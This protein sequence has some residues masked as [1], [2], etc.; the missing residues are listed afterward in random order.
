MKLIDIKIPFN[1]TII[2]RYFKQGLF[3]NYY[4]ATIINSDLLLS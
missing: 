2:K 3:L 4:L 1:D